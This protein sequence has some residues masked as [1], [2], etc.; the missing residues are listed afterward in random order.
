[1]ATKPARERFAELKTKTTEINA[2]SVYGADKLGFQIE[3]LAK[4]RERVFH[5]FDESCV[6]FIILLWEMRRD[7]LLV[8]TEA[9]FFRL[10][11][12]V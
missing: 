10:L 2:E 7:V 9:R 1:L 12:Q 4:L 5:R 8:G 3:Q 6:C 11:R